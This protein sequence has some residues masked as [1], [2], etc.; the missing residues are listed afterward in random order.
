MTQPDKLPELKYLYNKQEAQECANIFDKSGQ[1][2]TA[3]YAH[4]L[5]KGYDEAFKQNKIREQALAE[6]LKE[7]SKMLPEYTGDDWNLRD[8]YNEIIKLIAELENKE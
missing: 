2:C 1:G 6:R 8:T 4:G 3:H 5:V 7:I